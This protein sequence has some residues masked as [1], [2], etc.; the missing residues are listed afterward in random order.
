LAARRLNPGAAFLTGLA[1]VLLPQIHDYTARGGMEAGL[2]ALLMVLL[3]ERAAAVDPDDRRGLAAAGM[4]GAL[5]FLARLDNVFLAGFVGL[6]LILK[7]HPD[8][9]YRATWG[10]HFSR[11]AAY[12]VPLVIA[13][14][15]FMLWSQAG[16]GTP[17]PV[18]GQVKRWWGTLDN[19]P[20][21]FPPRELKN[22]IGQFVTDDPDIGPW[23]LATAPLYRAAEAIAGE[24][25]GDRRLALAG[26]GVGLAVLAGWLAWRERVRLPGVI[27][28]LG[29]FPLLLGC[30]AQIAYYKLS[31]SVAQRPWYLI[32]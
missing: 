30:L 17:T 9:R 15:G 12:F 26:I 27:A 28:G 16:F 25:V 3:L 32:G 31:G 11:G 23:S 18:S 19:S 21:G 24:E 22:Y 1:F 10:R 7:G 2:S 14:A 13:V 6:G 4:V 29:L 8:L 20:Y 5:A